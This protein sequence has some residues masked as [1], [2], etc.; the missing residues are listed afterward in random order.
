MCPCVCDTFSRQLL[1]WILCNFFM[2]VILPTSVVSHH[3]PCPLV[4]GG[5][6]KFPP[7]N[8]CK[9]RYDKLCEEIGWWI[10]CFV[11]LSW[12]RLAARINTI[13]LQRVTNTN[14]MKPAFNFLLDK[15]KSNIKFILMVSGIAKY[16][17]CTANISHFYYGEDIFTRYFITQSDKSVAI[18]L[19][20]QRFIAQGL[21]FRKWGV[22]KLAFVKFLCPIFQARSQDS[23][24]ITTY[25]YLLNK[26]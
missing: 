1:I 17:R 13:Y 12:H 25:I 22:P 16:F 4:R 14:F 18:I 6:T 9:D 19:K 8:P 10:N 3:W 15:W 24:I 7:W 23:Q 21:K 20:G 11:K 26:I 2:T 5:D